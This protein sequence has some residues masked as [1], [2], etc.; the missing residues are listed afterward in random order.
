MYIADALEILNHQYM[1]ILQIAFENTIGNMVDISFIPHCNNWLS[2]D[3]ERCLPF[4]EQNCHWYFSPDIIYIS[5]QVLIRSVPDG[6]SEDKSWIQM[7]A[8]N[9]L[10]H[11]LLP[12]HMITK[13]F[14]DIWS[15]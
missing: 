6:L 10:G 11:I 1:Y 12:E 2:F 9:L 4:Y 13:I 15:S 5:T 3:F 14:H 7:M 8:Q